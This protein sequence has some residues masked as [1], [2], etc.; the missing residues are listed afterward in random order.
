MQ[1]PRLPLYPNP[2]NRHWPIPFAIHSFVHPSS[3]LRL[4]VA[5]LAV[6]TALRDVPATPALQS[7]RFWSIDPTIRM[8]SG[9]HDLNRRLGMKPGLDWFHFSNRLVFAIAAAFFDLR[10]A[11]TRPPHHLILFQL[12]PFEER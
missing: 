9:M 7:C 8:S 10:F 1:R 11:L 4:A 5:C 6:V 3:G 2:A 12:L